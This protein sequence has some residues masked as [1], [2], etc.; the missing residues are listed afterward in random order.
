MRTTLA[1]YGKT[2]M[3]ASFDWLDKSAH[4]GITTISGNWTWE[5]YEAASDAMAEGAATVDGAMYLITDMTTAQGVPPNAMTHA[6][7]LLRKKPSNVVLSVIVGIHPF[8]Q[9]MAN[10]FVRLYKVD[11][12][13]IVLVQT[14]DEARTRIEQHRTQKAQQAT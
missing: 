5:E 10:M 13:E 9:A 11:Q 3:P 8:V 12:N 1:I 14:V 6:R 4:I 7:R 2:I